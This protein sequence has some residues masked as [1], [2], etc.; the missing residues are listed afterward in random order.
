MKSKLCLALCPLTAAALYAAAGQFSSVTRPN[1]L[2][3]VLD[4]CRD[5][6]GAFGG[7]PDTKTPN[8][9]RLCG[10]GVVFQRAYTCSPLCNPTRAAIMN[11]VM[12]SKTGV[13]DNRQPFRDSKALGNS[14]TLPQYLMR[15]GYETVAA[16]KTY[17]MHFPDPL[18]WDQYSPVVLA[19][20]INVQKG[21][22]WEWAA[23][24]QNT[25]ILSRVRKQKRRRRAA[26]S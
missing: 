3:I 2:F 10:R 13:Y 15:H 24:D 20:A 23:V 18:S 19:E 11:G 26:K 4:D 16:G 6:V 8:L 12:P 14:V 25:L 21:E 1:I 22:Q 9:D 5:W 7:N 17:H